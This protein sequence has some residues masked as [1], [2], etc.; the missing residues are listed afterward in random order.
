MAEQLLDAA[1]LDARIR[2]MADDIAHCIKEKPEAALLGIRT[3]GAVLAERVHKI[4]KEVHK[5]DVPLGILDITLYRDDLSTLAA[6]PVVRQ[7]QLDFD[8]TGLDIYLV[9]D[10]LYTGRTV[11]SAIDQIV[12]FGRPRGIL[13]A[14]L[15]V[16]DGREFPIQADIAPLMVKTL[17]E[18]VV[19]VCLQETDGSEQVLLALRSE[20]KSK[21]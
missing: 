11:R 10:V 17:P 20:V 8:V 14:C 7:T 4:L 12:D 21:D 16:R 13:L 6:N 1:G 19:K 15:A 2:I 18:Q 9:D 3:R 5:L